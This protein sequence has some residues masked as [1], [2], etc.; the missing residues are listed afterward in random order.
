MEAFKCFCSV[1]YAT[2]AA[3]M[4]PLK[5]PKPYTIKYNILYWFIT[6]YTNNYIQ[7]YIIINKYKKGK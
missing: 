3:A 4:N 7:Q 2:N 1:R 6:K 5:Q